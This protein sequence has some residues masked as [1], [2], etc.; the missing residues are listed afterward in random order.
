MSMVESRKELSKRLEPS[1]RQFHQWHYR[2]GEPIRRVKEMM[3]ELS[4]HL[5]KTS[6]YDFRAESVFL[7]FAMK[8]NL[9]ILMNPART[10]GDI[11]SANGIRNGILRKAREASTNQRRTMSAICPYGK[12]K[13]E[14]WAVG[15]ILH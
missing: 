4:Y 9:L 6:E 5:R 8:P 15:V 1:K 14:M 2:E 3:D 13:M 12:Q 11:G 10:S 7:V